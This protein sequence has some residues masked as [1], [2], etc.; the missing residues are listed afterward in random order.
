M[1]VIQLFVRFPPG[2]RLPPGTGAPKLAPRIDGRAHVRGPALVARAWG[3]PVL[4]EE[5][6][7]PLIDAGCLLPSL[8]RSSTWMLGDAGWP[9]RLSSSSL[10][11]IVSM[12]AG[13]YSCWPRSCVAFLLPGPYPEFSGV[14]SHAL[15]KTQKAQPGCVFCEFARAG[16]SVLE[17]QRF[18][19]IRRQMDRN[20]GFLEN[21]AIQ[22]R[23]RPSP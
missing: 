7:R 6:I 3:N 10:T 12:L 14:W 15:S 18:A 9:V 19:R 20:R 1:P 11:R 8:S 13:A 17:I 21:A 5:L 16:G 23:P 2:L 4:M 22:H